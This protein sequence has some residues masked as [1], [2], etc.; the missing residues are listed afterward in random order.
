ML[1]FINGQTFGVWTDL[2]LG[3]IYVSNDYVKNTPFLFAT[4]LENH[5][6]NTLLMKSAK[7]YSCW[8]KFI[9]SYSLGVMRFENM[10]IKNICQDLIK[11]IL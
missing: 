3:K 7:K 6:E 2:T 9:D 5:K 10:K 8:R 11:S 4:T 1:S